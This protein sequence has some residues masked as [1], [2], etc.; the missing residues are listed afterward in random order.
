MRRGRKR[1]KD[2]CALA[3]FGYI[4]ASGMVD[5]R[6]AKGMSRGVAGARWRTRGK[7]EGSSER[8]R[9]REGGGA[10]RAK[11]N[12]RVVWEWRGGM[13]GEGGND[14]DENAQLVDQ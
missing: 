8:T 11:R 6:A 7:T 3:R 1:E 4:A 2:G 10:G 14:A 12:E 9:E 13:R 5:M